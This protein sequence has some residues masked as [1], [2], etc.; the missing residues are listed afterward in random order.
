MSEENSGT[1]ASPS[2]TEPKTILLIDDEDA[3]RSIVVRILRRAR[4]TVLE[5]DGGHSALALAASYPGRIDLVISD[6][7]MPGL[8]GPAVAEKLAESRPGLKV[9]FISGYA[10]NDVVGRSGVP[11]GSNFLQKPFST[12]ALAAAV[13]AAMG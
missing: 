1:S 2:S 12:E 9:L 3:V 6:L 11:A 13:S 8:H 5:A 4:Y 7:Y 10:D